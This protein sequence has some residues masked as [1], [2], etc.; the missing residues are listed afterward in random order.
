M[1]KS[2]LFFC[3][4]LFS[5]AL[6]AQNWSPVNGTDH[7]HFRKDGDATITATI[8]S[9]STQLVGPDTVFALNRISCDSCLTW[10]NGPMTACDTC[11][12]LRNL[13]QFLQRTATHLANGD[14]QFSDPG[15]ILF[16]ALAGVGYSWTFDAANSIT[17]TVSA[18]FAGTVFGN[19]DSIKVA[20]LSS[21][22]SLSWSKDH[23]LLLYPAA[24]G[25]GTYYR[26]TGIQTRQ[27]GQLVPMMRD[28][29]DIQPGDIFEYQSFLTNGMSPLEDQQ[30]RKDYITG[31][32]D[33][34][35]SIV[36]QVTT[37]MAS[38]GLYN[39]SWPNPYTWAW[40]YGSYQHTVIYEASLLTECDAYNNEWSVN[41]SVVPQ[42]QPDFRAQRYLE[43]TQQNRESLRRGRIDRDPLYNGLWAGGPIWT[44]PFSATSDTL[45]HYDQNV[46]QMGGPYPF[47]NDLGAVYSAG[48]GRTYYWASSFFEGS[49]VE[50]LTAYKKGTDTVGVFTPDGV[51]L[52]ITPL[53]T[54]V[55][56]FDVYPN[57]AGDQLFV[58][59]AV[60]KGAHL[61][62]LDVSGRE[63]VVQ[64]LSEPV[65]EI[66]TDALAA[67]VYFLQLHSSKGVT[68]KK[69]LITH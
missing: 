48:L 43:S 16:P 50:K 51:L 46:V 3:L 1:K 55:A 61:S 59:A 31:R 47:G 13:P 2:Y 28:F 38:Y 23:G 68:T 29:F 32:Q 7:F 52:G 12:G 53:Q 17:A 27:L 64:T 9:T 65:T 14:F 18:A 54:D 8:R 39:N 33:I 20:L 58:K 4:A 11:Y 56:T 6:H 69:V 25:S 44:A 30:T 24:Y 67:G 40:N 60:E 42:P 34:G 26:L 66:A 36:L 62:L 15:N 45:V 10:S 5:V 41:D 63:V 57:P 21:G 22:D 49:I 37:Y 35:D 19:A